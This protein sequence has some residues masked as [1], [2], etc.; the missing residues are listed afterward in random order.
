ML[1]IDRQ[2][3]AYLSHG[4]A[5]YFFIPLDRYLTDRS[6]GKPKYLTWITQK[7]Q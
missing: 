7:F 2:K 1:Q 6:G 5:G 3:W 4:V